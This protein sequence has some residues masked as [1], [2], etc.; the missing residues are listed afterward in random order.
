MN[1]LPTSD[2]VPVFNCHVLLQRPKESGGDYRA[3]C[4]TAV[5]VVSAGS[6]EREAL[7]SLV[8]RFK[9]FVQEH[10]SRGQAIPWT[11]PPLQPA[12]D[13]VERWVSIHL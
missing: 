3:R 7:Q 4:A 12:D 8:I 1:S 13:E 11:D 10:R 6:T 2:A 5:D 9:Y